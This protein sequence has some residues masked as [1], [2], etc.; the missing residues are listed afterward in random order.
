M[1]KKQNKIY[2]LINNKKQSDKEHHDSAKG[3][4]GIIIDEYIQ[5][6]A[7][8]QSLLHKLKPEDTL[9]V[10]NV[11]SLGKNIN[12]I[13]SIL[14]KI[15]SCKVNLCL[16]EENISFKAEKLPE[17]ANSLL[18]AFRLHQSLISLRSRHA[19]Q[20]KKAQGIKLGRPFGANPALKLDDHKNEIQQM[21]SAGISKDA[22]AEKYQVCRTTVYNFVK[23][24]PALLTIGGDR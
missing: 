23:K 17:I 12:E 14:Q 10:E 15:A 20:N 24:N 8:T 21:L 5:G 9:V 7:I 18:L 22:I 6:E 13:V 11:L 2:A 16:A 3:S 19:L 1:A 4:V